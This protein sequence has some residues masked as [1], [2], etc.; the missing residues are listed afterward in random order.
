S[1]DLDWIWTAGFGFLLTM[2]VFDSKD[3]AV[4]SR[5]DKAVGWVIVLSVF[6]MIMYSVFQWTPTYYTEIYGL[7]GRYFMPIIPL[8]LLCL[9]RKSVSLT[10]SLT[11]ELIWSCSALHCFT[12]LNIFLVILS[13]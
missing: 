8:A 3:R 1:L 2:S 9:Q 6:A 5:R 13:R 7:Q 4:L 12:V 10:K 11:S